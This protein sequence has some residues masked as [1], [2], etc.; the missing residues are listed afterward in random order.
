MTTLVDVTFRVTRSAEAVS[1]LVKICGEERVVGTGTD[2]EDEVVVSVVA[3]VVV[4]VV[5]V[6]VV[7]VVVETEVVD[8]VVVSADVVVLD[9]VRTLCWR[10]IN[11]NCG[12]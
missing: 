12:K 2:V 8:N 7:V 10:R 6:V 11:L 9:V 3:S 5:I 1:K 4:V